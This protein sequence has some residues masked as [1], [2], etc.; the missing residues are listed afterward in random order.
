[1]PLHESVKFVEGVLGVR[2]FNVR[3]SFEGMFKRGATL[4]FLSFVLVAQFAGHEGLGN[5]GVVA[6][7]QSSEIAEVAGRDQVRVSEGDPHEVVLCRQTLNKLGVSGNS[8]V[9]DDEKEL[10]TG[11][12]AGYPRQ[13]SVD[14]ASV[15]GA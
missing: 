15:G 3:N 7:A 6:H 13:L 4:L 12:V 5:V 10:T 2:Q 9:A 11:N 8:R 14:I 1:V